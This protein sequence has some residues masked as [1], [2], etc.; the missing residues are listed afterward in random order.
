MLIRGPKLICRHPLNFT[1]TITLI[2]FFKH[3]FKLLTSLP[4]VWNN[5]FWFECDGTFVIRKLL[6]CKMISALHFWL[7]K[8]KYVSIEL[9]CSLDS[10]CKA[11]CIEKGTYIVHSRV[12]YVPWYTHSMATIYLSLSAQVQWIIKKKNRFS[13]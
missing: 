10:F 5:H 12:P 4:P 9:T 6:S 2:R 7:K 1:V 13:L 8:E 3:I 11:D